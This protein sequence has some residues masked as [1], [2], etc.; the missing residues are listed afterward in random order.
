MYPSAA[1][2]EV[3]KRDLDEADMALAIAIYPD[4]TVTLVEGEPYEPLVE[5]VC[6]TRQGL[7]LLFPSLLVL[8]ALLTR[9]PSQ[10]LGGP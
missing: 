6:G 1:A 9:R 3:T 10:T 2:G 5:A 8:G 7:P 4:G